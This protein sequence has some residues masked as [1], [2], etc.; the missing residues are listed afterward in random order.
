MD[1]ILSSF[2]RLKE[3]CE[4][5]RIDTSMSSLVYLMGGGSTKAFF[6][7]PLPKH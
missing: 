7:M 5:D 1:I 2:F 4:I 6:K 3:I